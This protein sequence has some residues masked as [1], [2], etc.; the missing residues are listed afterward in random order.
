M[1]FKLIIISG[2]LCY[3]LISTYKQITPV[4][5]NNI[6]FNFYLVIL[7]FRLQKN[8]FLQHL[9]DYLS[10]HS[11][12]YYRSIPFQVFSNIPALSNFYNISKKIDF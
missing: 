12:D 2:T 7:F 10:D 3:L 9:P 4:F 8:H 5:N 1:P 11:N 6:A